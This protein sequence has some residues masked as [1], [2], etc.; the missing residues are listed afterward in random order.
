MFKYKINYFGNTLHF[1]D[2]CLQLGKS[3]LPT[4]LTQLAFDS[5]SATVARIKVYRY[6]NELTNF[7]YNIVETH[8]Y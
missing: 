7:K 6:F 5:V 3:Y 2:F 8:L 1:Y 4:Y